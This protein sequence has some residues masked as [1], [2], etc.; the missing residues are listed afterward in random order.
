[1]QEGKLARLIAGRDAPSVLEKE[2]LFERIYE[3]VQP[4]KPPR[5][6]GAWLAAGGITAAAALA[7]LFLRPSQPEF[8]A[9]GGA[10]LG[11]GPELVVA[12]AGAPQCQSGAKLTLTVRGAPALAG[13]GGGYFAAFARRFDGT[14]IW[15]FPEPGSRSLE[16]P[17]TGE[18]A[19]LDRAVLL[20]GEHL[21]GHYDLY[22]VFT[23][24]PLTREEL[25]LAVG[26]ELAGSADA[27]VVHRSFEVAR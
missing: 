8:Q 5:R 19:L 27:V 1:M 20:G 17:Q 9:R 12:C 21:P 13:Q 15:Y 24:R 18:R 26:E 22:G 23:R 7:L 25:K 16:L 6:V 2:Q 11:T 3:R 14:I 10:S 4:S